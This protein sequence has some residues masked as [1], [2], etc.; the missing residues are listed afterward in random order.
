MVLRHKFKANQPFHYGLS[1]DLDNSVV[2]TDDPDS[3]R[4]SKLRATTSSVL[5]SQ[6]SANTEPVHRN[7]QLRGSVF[8]K[9][10]FE[11]HIITKFL[12]QYI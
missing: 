2:V 12:I 7:R 5:P 3:R 4:W 10:K 11:I 9:I 6:I 1:I 8:G